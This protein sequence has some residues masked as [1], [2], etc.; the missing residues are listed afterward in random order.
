MYHPRIACECL[1]SQLPGE[2]RHHQ[3]CDKPA[4]GGRG[5]EQR[6]CLSAD[7][8]CAHSGVPVPPP[9]HPLITQ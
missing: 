8:T 2:V 6:A 5:D 9:A 4:S 1:D 7:N 3:A